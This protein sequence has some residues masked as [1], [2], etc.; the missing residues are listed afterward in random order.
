MKQQWTQQEI[1]R[2]IQTFYDRQGGSTGSFHMGLHTHNDS[3]SKRLIPE[4]SLMGFP[5]RLVA[6]ATVAPIDTPLNGTFRFLY[7][8]TPLYYLWVFINSNWVSTQLS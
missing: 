8:A 5:T 1:E 2:I 4:T 7:D 3:D 6:D